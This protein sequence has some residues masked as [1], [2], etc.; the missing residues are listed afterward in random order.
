MIRSTITGA[1]F[2]LVTGG[3]VQAQTFATYDSPG[4][5]TGAFAP[6][7]VY[8]AYDAPGAPVPAVEIERTT[9]VPIYDSYEPTAFDESA[10]EAAREPLALPPEPVLPV[11][12]IDGP[13]TATGEPVYPAALEPYA[14]PA[15]PPAPAPAYP[16]YEP[17]ALANDGAYAPAPA[18]IALPSSPPVPVF[19]RD[20]GERPYGVP[21]DV[22]PTDGM[23]DYAATAPQD[24]GPG[25]GFRRESE[26]SRRLHAVE[27]RHEARLAAL[28]ADHLRERRALIA[29]FERDASD[30]A[31]VVGLAE[32][33]KSAIRELEAAHRVR[34]DLAE[35]EKI[36]ASLAI[37]DSAPSRVE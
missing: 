36:A 29:A 8:R 21:V 28:K 35:Q 20:T 14:A 18:P 15:A 9:S 24:V 23:P 3:P 17:P 32:R 12:G 6:E 5:S 7:P 27:E 33:M 11:Y 16:T 22:T 31:K 13:A 30:P 25:P 10:Y 1:L 2:V 19:Q 34:L 4:P 26:T 37:L